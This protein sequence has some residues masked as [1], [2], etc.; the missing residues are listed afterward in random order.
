VLA[1]AAKADAELQAAAGDVL[2]AVLSFIMPAGS[3]R[4]CV[5]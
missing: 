1:A 4:T 2:Q 5:A 3:D